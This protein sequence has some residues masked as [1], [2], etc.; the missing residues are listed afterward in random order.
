MAEVITVGRN[1]PRLLEPDAAPPDPDRSLSGYQQPEPVQPQGPYW[2]ADKAAHVL[3]QCGKALSRLY[4][5]DFRMSAV[6][7]ELVGQPA[8]NVANDWVALPSGPGGDKIANLLALACVLALLVALRLPGILE[9]HDLLPRW[10]WARRQ[11]RTQERQPVDQLDGGPPPPAAYG[12]YADAATPAPAPPAAAAPPPFA[13]T[14]EPGQPA[15]GWSRSKFAKFGATTVG[16][17][18]FVSGTGA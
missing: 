18:D 3:A 1:R 7:L 14:S 12:P 11:K 2:T 15:P 16:G 13:G 17:G 5:P 4:G 10:A 9:A 6:E 8:A